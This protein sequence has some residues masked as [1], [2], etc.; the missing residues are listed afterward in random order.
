MPRSADVATLEGYDMS[1]GVEVSSMAK[2]KA[3]VKAVGRPASPAGAKKQI[4]GIRGSE[5]YKDWLLRFAEQQR[6]DMA[7]LVDDALEAYA[8]AEGFELPPKR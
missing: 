1:I 8:R 5:A 2:K 6:S 3:P 4:L 7:D